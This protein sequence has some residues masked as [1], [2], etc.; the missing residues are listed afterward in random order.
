[1]RGWLGLRVGGATWVGPL[2][3][4]LVILA[5]FLL[6]LG[7]RELFSSHEARAA[8]NAQRMLETGD[9]GLPT[10]FD[11]R[12]DLQKP[13]AYYWA[14]AVAGWLG[15]GQVTEMA[16]RLPAALAGLAC[17]VLVYLVSCRAD[18]PLA[19]LVAAIVLATANHFV[20]ISRT[21]RIDVPLAAAVFVAVL[22]FVRGCH[23][24]SPRWHGLAGAAAGVA[25]LLKG[26]VAV[27]L[28][29]PVAGVWFMVER[30][31]SKLTLTPTSV[32]VGAGAAAVVSLPWFIWAHMVTAGEFTRVF[33]WHHTIARF[34]GSS[35]Q[36]A[37]HP[38]WYYLPRLAFDFLPWTPLGIVLVG[39]ALRNRLWRHDPL[40]RLGLIGW[41][42]I[43]GVLSMARFKRADYVLP[44]YPFAALTIAAAAEA[45]YRGRSCPSAA[46]RG[47]QVFLA[48]A[49]AGVLAWAVVVF[50][51]ELAQQGRETKRAFAALI[52]AHAPPPQTVVQFRFESHHLSFHL[53]R[54]VRT[55]WE[56][57]DL[58]HALMEPGPVFVVMPPEYVYAAS[59]IC[60]RRH[61]VEIGRLTDFTAGRPER[62]L[63]FLRAE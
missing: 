36:L 20:A 23:L 30:R 19:A 42:V 56:W 24:A 12:P 27:A 8:Q 48:H 28:I 45:W 5:M 59:V 26:P 22:A 60:A 1:M 62:P 16:V 49:A 14:A 61:W 58:N 38:V 10:L 46:R 6:R 2:L 33:F 29:G 57:E 7:H 4:T 15:G 41:V 35:P 50:V 43:V 34:T 47:R 53:G 9:W 44:A 21:A 11:D 13:P 54:P 39:W 52:R 32:L 17:V 31:Y 18:R 37:T 55:L 3:T 40:F 51:V 63:V 25:V